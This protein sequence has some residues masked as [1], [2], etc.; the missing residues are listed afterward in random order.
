MEILV[1]PRTENR[2]VR[3]RDMLAEHAEIMAGII[4]L[5]QSRAL[6]RVVELATSSKLG[7]LVACL[8]L[9]EAEWAMR[10]L[11]VPGDRMPELGDG[12]VRDGEPN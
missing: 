11:T 12:T 8:M 5:K 4:A 1:Q 9:T 2:V 3:R 7:E 6:D 10:E